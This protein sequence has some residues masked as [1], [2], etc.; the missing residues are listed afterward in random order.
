[1]IRVAL[2]WGRLKNAL[3]VLTTSCCV[4]SCG[5]KYH[6]KRAI[7]KDPTI[8]Q[9]EI[10]QIDTVVVTEEKTLTD[11]LVLND[12]IVREITSKDGVVVRLQ[13][14]VDTI[15]V[16]VECPADTIRIEKVVEIP[17]VE[18]KERP[19]PLKYIVIVFILGLLTI[20][21]CIFTPTR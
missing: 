13:R 15:R 12:T 17:K 11:T 4:V 5:A 18:Y 14:V 6:L 7:A 10:V 19:I 21:F 3:V 1:M 16:D 9:S 2:R 20:L 8:L